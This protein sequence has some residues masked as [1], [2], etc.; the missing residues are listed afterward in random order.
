M[1]ILLFWWFLNENHFSVAKFMIFDK[2]ISKRNQKHDI[3]M[4]QG[5]QPNPNIQIVIE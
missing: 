3:P 4:Q 2:Q 5:K 1:L